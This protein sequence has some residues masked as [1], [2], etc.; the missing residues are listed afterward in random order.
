MAP[1]TKAKHNQIDRLLDLSTAS[2]EELPDVVREID[3]WDFDSQQ[4]YLADWPL[5]EDRLVRLAGYA[6]GGQMDEAQLARFHKLVELV[7]ENR[8]ILDRIAT[9]SSHD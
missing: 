6:D 8:P 9:G 3:G 5:E 4:T 1:V 7:Q 2:W